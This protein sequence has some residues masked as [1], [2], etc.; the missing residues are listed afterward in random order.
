MGWCDPY[1]SFARGVFEFGRKTWR[2]EL[3]PDSVTNLVIRTYERINSLREV[4]PVSIGLTL[5]GSLGKKIAD[6]WRNGSY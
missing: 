3:S 4:G 2:E 6:A 5:N 1:S